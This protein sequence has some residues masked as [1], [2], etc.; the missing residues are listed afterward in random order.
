VTPNR[1]SL[2]TYEFNRKRRLEESSV[3]AGEGKE[4]RRDV[5]APKAKRVMTMV[6][7]SV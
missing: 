7:L 3:G 1:R 5:G 6:S 2:G 4:S